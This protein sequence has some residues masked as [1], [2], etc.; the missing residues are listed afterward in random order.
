MLKLRFELRDKRVRGGEKGKKS[1]CVQKKS[2]SISYH[3]QTSAG[4]TKA[5]CELPEASVRKLV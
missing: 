5:S 1:I 3:T 2:L 4:H